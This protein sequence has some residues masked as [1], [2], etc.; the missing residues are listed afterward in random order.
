MNDQR[1]AFEQVLAEF[2][3]DLNYFLDCKRVSPN[4]YMEIRT[5]V[6]AIKTYLE[7]KWRGCPEGVHSYDCH[8]IAHRRAA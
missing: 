3:R 8:K 2:I 7:N 6:R 5:K 4:Q 1:T